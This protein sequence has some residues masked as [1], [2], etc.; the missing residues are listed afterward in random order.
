MDKLC[1]TCGLLLPESAF[2][3]HLKSRGGRRAHC[4]DCTRR[5]EHTKAARRCTIC[6][7]LIPFDRH[8][9]ATCSDTC[10]KARDR[11]NYAEL[12]GREKA[13]EYRI[14]LRAERPE[15]YRAYKSAINARRSANVKERICRNMRTAISKAIGGRIGK[16]LTDVLGYDFAAFRAH[17][18]ALWEPEMT[19][20]NYGEWQIDHVEP[21]SW[22][23][24]KT[25]RSK[26]FRDAWALTNLCPRW[27]TTEIAAAHGS[28]SVGN[29]E[30]RDHF[31]GGGIQ[32][33]L[34]DAVGGARG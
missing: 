17:I 8:G 13:L 11:R 23:D 34:F 4:T 22:F 20:D 21:V 18:E 15:G 2:Y 5:K 25:T 19:W 14:R 3:R 30:K 28:V 6:N 1:K 7:A 29:A 33:S 27:R 32:P 26:S 10:R 31:A 9:K 12:G 24:F 16:R